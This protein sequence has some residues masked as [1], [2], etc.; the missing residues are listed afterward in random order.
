[1][2]NMSPRIDAEQLMNQRV[3]QRETATSPAF[4]SRE[5]REV[6]PYDR[7]IFAGTQS[8]RYQVLRHV[9]T[10]RGHLVPFGSYPSLETALI[11]RDALPS[12]MRPLPNQESNE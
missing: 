2:V 8:N 5:T 1:M 11:A 3:M 4:A 6:N 10:G 9:R 7:V 12:E